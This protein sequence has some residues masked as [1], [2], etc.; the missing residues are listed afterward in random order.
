MHANVRPAPDILLTAREEFQQQQMECRGGYKPTP[1]TKP[2]D[3][4][5]TAT[6]PEPMLV[7]TGWAPVRVQLRQADDARRALGFL[8]R[9]RA[10]LQDR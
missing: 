3:I 2:G 4:T 9:L 7:G 6:V 1:M 8:A 5:V 10:A